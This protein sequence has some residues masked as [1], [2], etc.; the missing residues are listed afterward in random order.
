MSESE[1]IEMSPAL[2]VLALYVFYIWPVEAVLTWRQKRV[3][4][5]LG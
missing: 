2:A 4:L 1:W 3:L 5:V